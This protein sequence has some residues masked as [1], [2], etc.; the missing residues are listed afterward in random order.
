MDQRKLWLFALL[1]VAGIAVLATYCVTDS[2]TPPVEPAPVVE[3]AQPER[4]QTEPT[5]AIVNV[6]ADSIIGRMANVPVPAP[7]QPTHITL[8]ITVSGDQID[9][10]N[11][12]SEAPQVRLVMTDGD[13]ENIVIFEETLEQG[14]T[15]AQVD[16]PIPGEGDDD[17]SPTVLSALMVD[18]EENGDAELDANTQW[19]SV[20]FAY[21]ASEQRL[22]LVESLEGANMDE[23]NHLTIV[24]QILEDEMFEDGANVLADGLDENG[25]GTDAVAMLVEAGKPVLGVDI[26]PKV[27]NCVLDEDFRLKAGEHE[28]VSRA[29]IDGDKPSSVVGFTP[30][31][32]TASHG[33]PAFLCQ[34][35]KNGEE[36]IV[37]VACGNIVREIEVTTIWTP[38]V[39]PEP[40]QEEPAQDT[41]DSGDLMEDEPTGEPT[42]ELEDD[43]P[44]KDEPE[45]F[46]A[47]SLVLAYTWYDKCP[48]AS[49]VIV[50]SHVTNVTAQGSTQAEANRKHDAEVARILVAIENGEYGENVYATENAARNAMN[51]AIA[52]AEATGGCGGDDQELV[53]TEGREPTP[54]ADA[55]VAADHARSKEVAGSEANIRVDTTKDPTSAPTVDQSRGKPEGVISTDSDNENVDGPRSCDT[56]DL[57]CRDEQ[58]PQPGVADDDE[59]AFDLDDPGVG[60]G[61]DTAGGRGPSPTS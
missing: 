12:P 46:T 53:D 50:A 42:D 3:Q 40:V 49:T 52:F 43:A 9:G 51:D 7:A 11:T 39:K 17:N 22:V 18:G 33:V 44:V 6:P 29:K 57:V 35:M 19:T 4:A 25:T 20:P 30:V 38:I 10:A 23:D 26:D 59:L 5:E 36:W 15:T 1:V 24:L 47:K 45:D 8:T 16:V 21:D 54:N 56:H 27:V 13:H 58:H 55:E 14:E 48:S 60:V 61:G 28:Q 34:D 37:L 2:N 31:T 41:D 32:F